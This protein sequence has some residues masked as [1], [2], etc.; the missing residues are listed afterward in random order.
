MK[1]NP[2]VFMACSLIGAAGIIIFKLLDM[3]QFIVTSCPI[4]I[5][6]VYAWRHRK[7]QS[8]LDIV[9]DNLYYLGFLYTLVSLA[10]S[11]F[12]FS[13]NDEAVETIAPI[14]T[15]FGIAIFSTIFGIAFRVFFNLMFN[16]M[17]KG[18]EETVSDFSDTVRDLNIELR[19]FSTFR[20]GLE[21]ILGESRDRQKKAITQFKVSVTRFN[22]TVEAGREQFQ[23]NLDNLGQTVSGLNA[24]VSNLDSTV[25]DSSGAV[26]ASVNRLIE[27]INEM[28][29]PEDLIEQLLRPYIQNIETGAEQ[30]SNSVS[31]IMTRFNKTIE[32]GREQFQGNLDSLGQTV[33]GLNAQVSNLDSTVN[34]SSDVVA[35]SVNKLV[36]KINGVN[37]PEDLIEQLLRPYIQ[38]I[39]TG[40]E[41]ISNSVSAIMTRFNKTIEAGRE[42][43]QGNL[44]SLGQTV[45]G[46]NAQ[47]SNLDSTVNDS[48]DVVAASVNKLVEK[49]NGVNVPEDLIEQLLRPYIQ[50]IETGAEQISNSVSAI[51]T[52]FNKTIEA[53]HEQFQGNLDSLGQTVSGLN[54][55]VSNLD[56]AIKSNSEVVFTSVS[57]LVERINNIQAPEDF[58]EALLKQHKTSTEQ[59]AAE[60]RPVDGNP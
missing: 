25:N 23:G 37:V 14:I 29:V 44:D 39:E 48:S 9:G 16:L 28:N 56:S 40:A 52:R 4:A 47:V 50:N 21:Q 13:S 7:H 43:F 24:Q 46:L 59:I 22:E 58:M 33:S 3:N 38:N 45:S 32:A 11:L 2:K 57:D 19:K 34:D 27:K 55:Q 5:M 36:E 12:E 18:P 41:Q 51:M 15:N 42:Q 35:A 49:I 6:L 10:M 53:G 8:E 20:I 17:H 1:L 26:A 54:A 60:Q 31:A 30:I